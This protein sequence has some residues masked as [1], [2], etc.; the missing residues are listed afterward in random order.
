MTHTTIY[1]ADSLLQEIANLPERKQ[2]EYVRIM[3]A[4]LIGMQLA[5]QAWKQPDAAPAQ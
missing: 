5:E 2:T 4:V 1:H 3:K